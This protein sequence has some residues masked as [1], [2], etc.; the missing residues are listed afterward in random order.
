MSQQGRHR[1]Q[2]LLE[3][4]LAYSAAGTV[5]LTIFS[6]AW[7]LLWL[8]RNHAQGLAQATGT[9]MSA[10]FLLANLTWYSMGLSPGA[11][12]S[13]NLQVRTGIFAVVSL[14]TG[15]PLAHN[16]YR[17]AAAASEKAAP[18]IDLDDLII[19]TASE[20][21]FSNWTLLLIVPLVALALAVFSLALALLALFAFSNGELVMQKVAHDDHEA[22]G[23]SRSSIASTTSCVWES[24][25]WVPA[26]WT[27]V[28][29]A[30]YWTA[31]FADQLGSYIMGG[32]VSQWYFAPAVPCMNNLKATRITL[33]Y[34]AHELHKAYKWASGL[35][36]R[37][38]S[39]RSFP[40]W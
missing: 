15:L 34:A 16:M 38:K 37:L 30:L 39:W 33:G 25:K 13:I 36:P 26:Y 21:L 5:V 4:A 31:N 35:I 29:A 10:V 24:H 14:I 9:L 40:L 22:R 20:S 12:E 23:G 32:I 1:H 6:A 19:R 28:V 7:V 17:S 27:L 8:K 2:E 3:K 11:C 18:V